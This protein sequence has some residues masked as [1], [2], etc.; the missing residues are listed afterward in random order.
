[1]TQPERRPQEKNGRQPQKKNGR[2]PQKKMKME[3]NLHFFVV[4]KLE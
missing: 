4:E 2:Q 3:D 1:L